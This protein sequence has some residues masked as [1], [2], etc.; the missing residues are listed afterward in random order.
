MVAAVDGWFAGRVGDS[1]SSSMAV[2]FDPLG[3][4]APLS[5]RVGAGSKFDK[6]FQIGTNYDLQFRS[7]WLR[8]EICT[9]PLL[10]PCMSDVSFRAKKSHT[11][12]WPSMKKRQERGL[13]DL[14]WIIADQLDFGTVAFGSIRFVQSANSIV[15]FPA[16][17]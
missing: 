8:A 10:P 13:C 7:A 1:R 17:E 11:S 2:A 12:N 15:S 9:A 4:R 6:S 16:Q 14:W 3:I 5:P